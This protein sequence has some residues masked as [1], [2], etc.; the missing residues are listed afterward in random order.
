[1]A[2]QK[3]KKTAETVVPKS[4]RISGKLFQSI[5]KNIPVP[6]VD[7]LPVRKTK[8]GGIEV[9]LVKRRIY[10][11]ERKWVLIGGRIIKGEST[12][13]AIARQ[14]KSE[15]GVQAKIVPPFTDI[16][17]FSVM[18][19]PTTDKQKHSIAL[20]YLV[21][22]SKGTVKKSGPE[23]SE[24]KWFSIN[25]LPNQIGF[26]FKKVL[27]IFRQYSKTNSLSL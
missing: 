21:S 12:K 25:N 18:N 5:Q 3:P 16:R 22:R 24:A 1:M 14:A 23:F 10:P 6:C 26:N 4:K 2:T 8:N 20:T 13:Q 27:D 19:E 9:L 11:E 17:P 7:L 15:L